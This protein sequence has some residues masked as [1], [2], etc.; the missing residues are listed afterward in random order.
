MQGS[1]AGKENYRAL[2][3]NIGSKIEKFVCSWGRCGEFRV[4]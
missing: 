3:I 4:D 1:G 2:L